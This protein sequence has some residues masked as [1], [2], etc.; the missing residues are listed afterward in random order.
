MYEF[1]TPHNYPIFLTYRCA[2]LNVEL[3]HRVAVVHGVESGDLVD[4]HRRHLQDTRNLVHDADASETVLSLS[5]VEQRHDG[6]L[7]ILA[8]V[9]GQHFLDELLILGIEFEGDIEVVL[10]SVA[11]LRERGQIYGEACMRG[12]GH[13]TFKLSLLGAVDTRN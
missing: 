2:A 10:G 4:S 6:G 12:R 3:A 9:A 5:E 1:R 7:L 8:G 11:V 13:T